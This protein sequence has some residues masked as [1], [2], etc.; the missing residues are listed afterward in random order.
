MSDT[1]DL[2]AVESEVAQLTPD[3]IKEQ[4]LKIRVRQKVQQKKQQGKGAQKNYQAKANA[5]RNALK[6]QAIKLGLWDEINEE[7]DKQAE[8][9][10]AEVSAAE[11]DESSSDE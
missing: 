2:S 9:K 7:A 5:T 4:L 1:I 6:A 3:Q 10:F 8:A 11:A